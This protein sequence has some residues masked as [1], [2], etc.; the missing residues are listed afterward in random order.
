MKEKILKIFREKFMQNSKVS[1]KF[2]FGEAKNINSTTT[3]KKKILISLES[4]CR[5]KRSSFAYKK[6]IFFSW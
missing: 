1:L 5:M 6:T 2:L 3:E 4:N